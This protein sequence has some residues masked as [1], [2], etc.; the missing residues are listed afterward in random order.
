MFDL[1]TVLNCFFSNSESYIGWRNSQDPCD[2]SL[3]SNLTTSES[4][5][6]FNDTHPL[7]TYKNIKSIAVNDKGFKISEWADSSNYTTGSYVEYQV[8]GKICYFVSLDDVNLDNEPDISP[9]FWTQVDFLSDWY[10]QK[11]KESL[12]KLIHEIS[13]QKKLRHKTKT[14]LDNFKLFKN[15]GRIKDLITKSGRF[16]GYAIQTKQSENIQILIRQIGLQFSDLQTDLPIYLYHTSQNEPLSQVTYSTTKA[17]SFEWLISDYLL[18][19]VDDSYDTGMFFLGYYED[20]ITGQAIKKDM[21]WN[22][23]C[24]GCNGW[25]R[26]EYRSFSQFMQ[27]QPI[28]VSSQDIEV[29]RELFDLNDVRYTNNT[30]WGINLN[31]SIRCDWSDFVC[32]NKDIFR[33]PLKLQV[34]YDFMNEMLYSTRDNDLKEKVAAAIQ[35]ND[36]IAGIESKLNSQIESLSFDMS[37]LGSPCMPCEK[38]AGTRYSAA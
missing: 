6:Y 20:D 4:G 22:N 8:D 34:A 35:G 11:T 15:S 24:Y 10:T 17:S 12:D 18:K 38:R 1:S 25:G 33:N 27:I 36:A 7:L 19:Y 5:S 23:P 3:A 31:L 30:N 32:Q 26:E 16:V 21:D 2:K 29:G 13:E 14:I 28:S 37:D 9:A